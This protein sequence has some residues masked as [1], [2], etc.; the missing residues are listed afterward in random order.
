MLG[1]RT[2]AY[3]KGNTYHMD[4]ANQENQTNQE[5]LNAPQPQN[6][7]QPVVPAE[8]QSPQ[9]ITPPAPQPVVVSAPQP[10]VS[11]SQPS[12]TVPPSPIQQSSVQSADV[13]KKRKKWPIV[14]GIIGA[15]LIVF[16]LLILRAWPAIQQQ[17]LARNFM[18]DITSGK[19]DS[20]VSRTGDP[21]SKPYLT[22]AAAKLKGETPTYKSSKYYSG[23]ESYYLF[24]LSGGTYKS[25]RVSIS[26][27]NGKLVVMSFVYDTQQ[28]KLVPS[29]G[30]SATNNSPTTATPT[31][32]TAT[33]TAATTQNKCLAAA[34]FTALSS[35]PV[36]PESD[37]TYVWR[38]S[39]FFNADAAT[40]A[41]P[42]IM[43]DSYAKYKAFYTQESAK[44]FTVQLTG[45]VNSTAS[46]A[47]LATARTAKVQ[48]DLENLAGIPASRIVINAP[49]N[50]G[51]SLGA[52]DTGSQNR[53]VDIKIASS[54]SCVK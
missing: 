7:S 27:D 54:S 17:M 38:D 39:V 1:V 49:T 8:S 30:S 13:P 43:P 23:S 48:A 42:D 12:A 6:I 20:A 35:Y 32:T 26:K 18:N 5:Q 24:D 36:D 21:T 3:Q 14:A 53:N 52:G 25:A 16:A 9:V 50:Y 19:L 2:N 4:P 34:D 37:G 31:E 11:Q 51:T 15:L 33:N 40:Y 46:D 41:Y 29:S 47:T 44:D 28:L 45:E 22:T 10:I